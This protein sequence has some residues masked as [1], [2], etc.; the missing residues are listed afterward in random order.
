MPEGDDIELLREYARDGSESAFATLVSRYVNLVYSVA[1]QRVGNTHHAEEVAQAVFIILARKAGKISDGV[2]L[3]G[4][5]Y[6]TTQLT[7][8]NFLRGEARRTRREQE[9]HMQSVLEN[10]GTETWTRI[11]PLLHEA[12]GRLSRGDRD[13]IVLRYFENK[14]VAELAAAMQVGEAAAHKRLM[15]AVERLRGIFARQGVKV[16]AT[17]LVTLVAANSVSAAP[18]GLAASIT[19]TAAKGAMAGGTTLTLVKGGLKV[20]AWTKAKIAAV[21]GMGLAVAVLTPVT[22][23]YCYYH[24]GKDAWRRQFEATYRL[25]SGENVKHVQ[26][27]YIAARAEYYRLDPSTRDQAKSIPKAPDYFVFHDDGRKLQKWGMSF[28]G[29]H[30]T[31]QQVLRHAFQMR[32]Y[33]LEGVGNVLTMNVDGDWVFRGEIMTDI[34]TEEMLR[35]LGEVLGREKKRSMRFEKQTVDREVI[36]AHGSYRLKPEE[37]GKP[38]QVEIYASNAKDSNNGIGSGVMKEFLDSLGDTLR[39]PVIDETDGSGMRFE[40]QFHRDVF[41]APDDD[42]TLARITTKV[43]TNIQTQTGLTFTHETRPVP[44]WVVSAK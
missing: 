16:S 6:H 7:A 10:S 31:L 11:A 36:V 9:A 25:S 34:K 23:H 33:E 14:S 29:G 37:S 41:T 35:E 22:V 2:V 18:T 3:S 5:L 38:K 32:S 19:A 27:P 39:T 30:S 42:A 28:G 26:P 21:A 15:R 40:W 12:M 43:L 4:W 13:A 44:V 20:M 24:V 17:A 1:L 8:G